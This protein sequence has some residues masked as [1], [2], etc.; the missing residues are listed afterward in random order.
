MNKALLKVSVWARKFGLELCPNKTVH[1]IFTNKT[2]RE[3]QGQLSI[4]GKIIRE[5]KSVKYLGVTLDTR[6]SWNKHIE[7]KI[8]AGRKTIFLLRNTLG[9]TWGPT[10]EMIKWC[11]TAVIRPMVM[12]AVGIWGPYTSKAN[13]AKL[14]S[15]QRLAL[16]GM[17]HFRKGT[18]NE[19]LNVVT[20]V[21]PVDIF[22][23]QQNMLTFM[24]LGKH[25][26]SYDSWWEENPNHLRAAKLLLEQGGI[27]LQDVDLT[28][29]CRVA[30][31]F[32]VNKE[33]YGHGT[34]PDQAPEGAGGALQIFTDGSRIEGKT[35]C[36]FTI[37][38]ELGLRSFSYQ[39]NDNST[40]H[41]M[42][43]LAIEQAADWLAWTWNED[44]KDENHCDIFVDNQAILR[45]LDGLY[46]RDHSTLAAKEALNMASESGHITL[47]W[48]KAHNGVVGNETAD[49][50]AK[51][52]ALNPQA[53]VV[54]TMTPKSHVKGQI[55]AFS[56]ALWQQ[57]WDTI[58]SCRQ[59][60]IF[61][62]KIN[63][64]KSKAICS[65][66]RATFSRTVRW[67]TGHNF[68]RQHN[69][70]TRHPGSVGTATC[71]FCMTTAESSAHI[72]NDCESFHRERGNIF[73][74]YWLDPHSPE[75][76]PNQ[77]R[78]FL[79]LKPVTLLEEDE[80]QPDSDT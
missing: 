8:S 35:G 38:T 76:P 40:V 41:Q 43:A 14:G 47:H 56:L 7:D 53:Q 25:I 66:D 67:I 1:M 22:A 69:Q 37:E 5:V 19:G 44:S 32:K 12:Y 49:A 10:P 78:S 34:V 28:T 60:K 58:P 50:A 15:L 57:R 20:G 30:K 46:I 3:G 51:L 21:E 4:D 16:N 33:S 55:K 77:L 74:K 18:P 71:R 52:G 65:W 45:G 23:R 29:R 39:G 54:R 61:M 59:T 24:R 79:S 27:D 13:W 9:K 75:W 64:K 80:E 63:L 48:V 26:A 2:L 62:P 68:L 72:I 11:Y 73:Q 31:C 70:A 17:G 6:L 36:G 42:E